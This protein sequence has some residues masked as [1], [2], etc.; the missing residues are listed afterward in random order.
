MV[1]VA[2][3]SNEGKIG[4]GKFVNEGHHDEGPAEVPLEI[5][6]PDGDIGDVRLVAS[7]FRK[8]LSA[9]QPVFYLFVPSKVP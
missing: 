4:V 3:G 9:T 8:L 7:S 1:E 6:V 5:A 2:E